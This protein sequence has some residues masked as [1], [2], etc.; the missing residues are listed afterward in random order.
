[1]HKSQILFYTLL[2][3]VGGVLLASLI[4]FSY[5]VILTLF[6]IALGF[7]AVSVYRETYSFRFFIGS[8]FF[9]SAVLGIFRFVYFDISNSVLEQFADRDAGGKPVPLLLSGYIDDTPRISGQTTQFNF[10][11]KELIFSDRTLSVNE[12]TRVTAVGLVSGNIGDSFRL[13]GAIT[14]PQN[15]NDE[16]DYINYLRKEGIKT[17]VLFPD[18]S[19]GETLRIGIT[20]KIR[21]D[22]KEYTS[23]VRKYFEKAVSRSLVEPNAGYINGI[24]LGS[25]QDIPDDLREAF[26]KTGTTHI[27]AISGYNIMIIAGALLAGLVFFVRRRTAFWI[28]VAVIFLFTI[29]TGASASVV[30]ASVMGLLILFAQ[31]YGRMY[32]AKNSIILAG[33]LMVYFNPPALAFDIGFQL[34]FLAV[35]GLLYLYPYLKNKFEK[36]PPVFGLKDTLLTTISAQAMVAIPLIFYFGRF[37]WAFLPANVLILPLIPYAMLTGLIAGLGQIIFPAVAQFIAIPAWA[38]TSYQIWIVRLFS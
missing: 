18:I 10:K 8:I 24:L 34:S 19:A 32:D 29:M 35:I 11:V 2:S 3:F 36:Y 17:T 27:L 13:R 7:L 6:I 20:E 5:P 22:I 21:L 33:A 28:S 26:N 31:G 15:F 30:R 38:I 1:M 23:R 12:K 25:R 16:F 37:S 9:I 4:S 14:T